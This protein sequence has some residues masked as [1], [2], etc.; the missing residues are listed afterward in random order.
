MA[1]HGTHGQAA[2][3]LSSRGRD[4]EEVAERHR[5]AREALAEVVASVPLDLASG[6][7]RAARL[8][9]LPRPGG[10]GG[11]GRAGRA[12]GERGQVP[13]RTAGGGDRHRPRTVPGG[14][15][16]APAA[17]RG[18]AARLGSRGPGRRADHGRGGRGRHAAAGR[19]QRDLPRTREPI[20]RP[21]RHRLGLDEYGGAVEP[22]AS[23]GVL[24][25]TRDGR[26]RV[27]PLGVAGAGR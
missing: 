10:R 21:A 23:S 5:R 13:D 2:F 24:V 25:G 26:Q 7:G 6:A 3:F 15:R 22:Q 19:P 9:P 17:R 12:G 16:A 20:R 4:I 8:G 14:A 1:R 27:A 18:R 11:R